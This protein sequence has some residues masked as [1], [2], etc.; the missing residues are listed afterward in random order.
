M[1][2]HDRRIDHHVFVIVITRQ[3]FE[4]A[5]ENAALG[6]SA[7]ALVDIS[8]D[9]IARVNHGTDIQFCSDKARLRRTGD[10][11]LPC[12]RHGLRDPVENP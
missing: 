11:L 12:L 4:N 5:F 3:H 7:E 10:Y 2:P 6:P 9:Q 8:S 1:S